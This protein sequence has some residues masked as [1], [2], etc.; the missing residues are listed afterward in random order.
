MQQVSG[1]MN[2]QGT[3]LVFNAKVKCTPIVNDVRISRES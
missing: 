1:W 2:E 3:E